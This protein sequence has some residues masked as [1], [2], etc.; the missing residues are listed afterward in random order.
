MLDG[1]TVGLGT[2]T[3]SYRGAAGETKTSTTP[4]HGK[5]LFL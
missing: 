5:Q 3:Y 2:H 4:A 1:Q